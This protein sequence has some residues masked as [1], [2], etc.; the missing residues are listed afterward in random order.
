MLNQQLSVDGQLSQAA[1][2][3]LHRYLVYDALNHYVAFLLHITTKPDSDYFSSFSPLEELLGD[4][5]PPLQQDAVQK[6]VAIARKIRFDVS[7]LTQSVKKIYNAGEGESIDSQIAAILSRLEKI[8]TKVTA[9]YPSGEGELPTALTSFVIGVFS[10]TDGKEPA[11]CDQHM[12]EQLKSQV[13]HLLASPQVDPLSPLHIS[14]AKKTTP[15]SSL[16]SLN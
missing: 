2:E 1:A 9:L 16:R 5:F 14:P 8:S 6:A 15:L 11:T 7:I 4:E 13:L 12:P 3:E 10:S